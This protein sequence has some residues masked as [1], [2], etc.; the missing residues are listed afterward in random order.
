M[1]SLIAQA[2]SQFQAA[3]TALKSGD[4][5]GYGK[6]I[7]ALSATLKQLQAAK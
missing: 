4:F 6:Q 3:Q 5:A 1:K 7:K 2:N